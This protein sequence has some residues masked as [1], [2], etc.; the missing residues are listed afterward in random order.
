MSRLFNTVVLLTPIL[1]LSTNIYAAD[2]NLWLEDVDSEKS[3]AWVKQT[4]KAT[5][6][7]LGADPLYNSLYQDALTALNSKDKLPSITQRGDW[8]YN[9]WKDSNHP[10]GIYRRTKLESFNSSSP[11]WHIVLDIDKMSMKDNVKW[12]FKGM[13][14]LEPAYE[15]CLV[16]LSPGGGGC[17]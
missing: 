3:L 4:N 14:C 2:E 17:I 9:Y 15:K 12:V 1:L 13:N 16:S 6:A 10:R 11:E 8:I 7:S 5:D